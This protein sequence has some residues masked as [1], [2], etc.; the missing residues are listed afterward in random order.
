MAKTHDSTGSFNSAALDSNIQ[1]FMTDKMR[2]PNNM[3]ALVDCNDATGATCNLPA[4]TVGTYT[5]LMAPTMFLANALAAPSVASLSAAGIT[6][7]YYNN[8]A[9]ANATFNSTVDIPTS[10]AATSIVAKVAPLTAGVAGFPETLTV[11]EHLAAA[12]ERPVTNFDSTCYDY[13]VFGIGDRTELVGNTMSTAPVHFASQGAM[14]P[15][16]KYNRFVAVFQ[17]DKVNATVPAATPVKAPGGVPD[18]GGAL[19]GTNVEP[20]KFIGSA[21]TMGAASGHLWGTSHSLAHTWENVAAN[22]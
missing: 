9:T 3:E 7:V 11:E 12:F 16:N 19:C 4:N 5:K 10:L 2:A 6:N 17:V 20:A 18:A 13:V 8:N 14:G 1:R 15:A 22:N 21:M